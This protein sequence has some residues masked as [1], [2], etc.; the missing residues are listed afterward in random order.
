MPHASYDK[1]FQKGESDKN[2][3]T[4]L[5]LEHTPAGLAVTLLDAE[6]GLLDHLEPELD[7]P[8]SGRI[9]SFFEDGWN[10]MW[11]TTGGAGVLMTYVQSDD[12]IRFQTFTRAE[13]LPSNN[14][15]SVMEDNAGMLWVSTNKGLFMMHPD[16]FQL[17][18]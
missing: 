3:T 6:L 16:N 4:W 15:C 12:S 5:V 2:K 7:I 14:T 9:T 1:D 13:G 10:R 8:G 18:T 17:T 11:V